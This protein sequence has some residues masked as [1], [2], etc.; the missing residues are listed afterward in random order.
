MRALPGPTSSGSLPTV[1]IREIMTD[2][3]STDESTYLINN[4][5]YYKNK[6]MTDWIVY[7]YG[8]PSSSQFRDIDIYY[9]GATKLLRVGTYGRGIW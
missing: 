1:N 3:T 6:N 8:M 9:S 7:Y 2:T 5:V 4:V